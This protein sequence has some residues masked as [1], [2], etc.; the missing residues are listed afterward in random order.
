LLRDLSIRMANPEVAISAR[1]AEARLRACA[2]I[3]R[4]RHRYALIVAMDERE[5]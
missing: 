5:E 1:A 3:L 4:E 2:D